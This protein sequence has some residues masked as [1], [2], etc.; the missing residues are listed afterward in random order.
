MGKTVQDFSAP[1]ELLYC[2]TVIF[3]IQKESCLLSVTDIHL[4]FHSVFFNL[5]K[6]GKFRSDKSFIQF[7]P[8]PPANLH[9]TSL[10]NPADTDPVLQKDLL[11]DPENFH[12]QPV[13]SQRQ[14]LY[15]K[16]V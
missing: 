1:A 5:D 7:H 13:D 8:F 10:V 4:I 6:S 12:F 14:G 16:Y 3:L 9:I 11:Q 2:Q 15:H